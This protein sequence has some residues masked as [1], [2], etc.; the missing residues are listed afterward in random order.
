MC[1]VRRRRRMQGTTVVISGQGQG[2]QG[3]GYGD[4]TGYEMNN[5]NNT[6]NNAAANM[7]IGQP[8]MLANNQG[9]AYQQ[10]NMYL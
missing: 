5:Y 1:C 2:Y 4:N 9:N 10:G 6:L 7:V 3:G 8:V